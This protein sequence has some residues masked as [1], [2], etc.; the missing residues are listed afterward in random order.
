MRYFR[1]R[2]TSMKN[3]WILEQNWNMNTSI[4]IRMNKPLSFK[5]YL[6]GM[7]VVRGL[8]NGTWMVTVSIGWAETETNLRLNQFVDC[9]CLRFDALFCW[10]YYFSVSNL[11]RDFTTRVHIIVCELV[12]GQGFT[13]VSS[14]FIR[15]EHT[16]GSTSATAHLTIYRHIRL[17][18]IN[19]V[20]NPG[21]NKWMFHCFKF[22]S[23]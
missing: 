3:N 17:I 15:V 18:T 11:K 4:N 22:G 5:A 19:R 2:A 1:R 7:R 6:Y 20:L 23:T 16:I 21:V 9:K 13:F 8:D 14:S 10:L 12:S